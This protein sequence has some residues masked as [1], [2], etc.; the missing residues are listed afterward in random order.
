MA[1]SRRRFI[2]LSGAAVGALAIGYIALKDEEDT[3]LVFQKTAKGGEV[4]LNAWLKIDVNGIVTIAAPRAE[5][6]QGVHTALAMLVAEELD[7]KW[8]DVRIEDA[9]MHEVYANR[10]VV[11]SALPFEDGFHRGE[12]TAGAGFMAWLSEAINAQATGGSTSVRDAWEPMRRAGACARLMLIEAAA[13]RWSISASDCSASDGVVRQNGSDKQFT[14]GDLAA[15]ASAMPVPANP[16]MKNPNDYKLVGGSAPRLDIAAKVTG[17]AEFG[18]D[19]RR[20]DMLY[21]AVRNIPS[22]GGRVVRVDQNSISEMPGVIG[23]VTL[24]DG[25]AVVADSWWRAKKATDALDVEFDEG[26]NGGLDSF[27]ISEMLTDE[28]ANGTK[29]TYRDDGDIEE[30]AKN[31]V[32]TV[33]A[34]YQ[35][36]YLAH[37]CMEPMNCTAIIENGKVEV[38][39]PNQ[40]PIL[41]QFMASNVADVDMDDVTVHTTYLG[42]GFGRRAEADLLV[43]AVTL[44]RTYPGKMIKVLWSREEDIQHDMYRPAA[45][46]QFTA[47]LDANGRPTTWHNRIAGQVPTKSFVQRIF[48]FAGLDMP[49]NTSSEGSADMPYAVPNLLVEHVPLTLPVPVGFWRSVGHSYNA[50]FTECFMDELADAAGKDPYTYRRELLDGHADYLAVLDRAAKEAGWDQ[51]VTMGRGRGIALHESFG[52]LV[53]QVAEI[54]MKGDKTFRID[55]VVCV[56]DCGRVINADTVVA[57][58]QSGIIYGLTAA[59]YGDITLDKGAVQQTNFTDYEMVR[60]GEEPVI[61]VHLAPSGRPLGGIG[62]VGTPPIAPAL[63][64][65]IFDATGNRLRQL[66]IS[67]AGLSV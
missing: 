50:F 28:L 22:F 54:T 4:A 51:P 61:E 64:N 57:Q 21:A 58:M 46:S 9:P 20:D 35:V 27:A 63:V 6:G 24:P 37:A 26:D 19:V 8:S 10:V 47:T 34:V 1:L 16:P 41:M 5:M 25:V 43:Q 60:L 36:P 31:A 55:R 23:V 3:R 59:L 38:W 52:S 12:D 7:V 42:G 18:I 62:E 32:K 56:V 49:D 13:Q 15:A 67:K 39:M 11:Q 44:A 48:P 40:A 17:T 65:A 45:M 30:A 2:V 14:Y 53:A 66:P 29:F 33:E